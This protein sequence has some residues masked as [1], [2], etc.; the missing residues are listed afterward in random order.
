MISNELINF[1]RDF[2][3]TKIEN[4]LFSGKTLLCEFCHFWPWW[5]HSLPSLFDFEVVQDLWD[6]LK[7]GYL[8][9]ALIWYH[10]SHLPPVQV[11]VPLWG[12]QGLCGDIQ[13][14]LDLTP[15]SLWL[16]L[17]IELDYGQFVSACFLVSLAAL[18]ALSHVTWLV[19][20]LHEVF[21]IWF[22]SPGILTCR[23]WGLVPQWGV[24]YT[25]GHVAVDLHELK[26][27]H[28]SVF[29]QESGLVRVAITTQG[30]HEGELLS[31]CVEAVLVVWK[32]GLGVLRRGVH[33]LW[34][35]NK[36]D[37]WLHLASS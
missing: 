5:T 34:L 28:H 4:S 17:T 29:G 9:M 3:P 21:H 27:G 36:S 7:N 35:D 26:A 2:Y 14:Q 16:H 24:R 12:I 31:L 22:G 20:C 10:P 6:V 8:Q 19:Q 33:L 37:L 1:L 30:I 11:A 15:L 18:L 13:V 32:W 23:V 25:A